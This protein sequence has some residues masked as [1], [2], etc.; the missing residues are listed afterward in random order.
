M[1]G[2]GAAAASDDVGACPDEGGDVAGH[3]VG[4]FGK[5]GFAGDVAGKAGVGVDEDRRRGRHRP[6]PGHD[7]YHAFN[8]VAAV[9][10]DDV[11]SGLEG[12][13]GGVF[14]GYAHHASIV[15]LKGLFEGEGA[16]HFKFGAVF[17]GLDG[18]DGFGDVAHR[19]YAYGVGSAFFEGCGLDL[20]GFV[21]FG[22]GDVLHDEEFAGGAYGGDDP[23]VGPGGLAGKSGGGPVDLEGFVGKAVM[24][25]LEGGSAEAV[26]LDHVGSRGDVALGDIEDFGWPLEAPGFG[27]FA[28]LEALGVEEGSPGPIGNEDSAFLDGLAD[29]RSRHG[30]TLLCFES[31]GPKY[32]R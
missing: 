1:R 32:R 29:F 28:R 4:L 20:E 3:F 24:G 25:E 16:D 14:G 31:V 21:E 17:G 15:A 26:G 2:R 30:C 23:L 5:D 13:A 9:G 22:F 8:A 6:Y 7:V 19:F 10:A 27:T 18:L 12:G 11:G